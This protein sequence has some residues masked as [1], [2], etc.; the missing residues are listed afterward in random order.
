[1][2]FT[3]GL[4]GWT[5]NDWSRSGNFDLMAPRAEVDGLTRDRVFA[6]LKESW[7]ATPE[8]L[9]AK[10]Q[11]DRATVL[12]AL[13]IWTQ[14][15]RAIYDLDQGV[16][17]CRELSQDPLPLDALRFANP[18]EEA[19]TRFLDDRRVQLT[20]QRLG[21]DGLLHLQGTVRDRRNETVTVVVDGDERI[22]RAT[23]TCSFFIQNK[24][25]KGPC[26]HI[27]AV[28]MQSAA[29]VARHHQVRA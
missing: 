28:R 15:G 26:Q 29:E 6:A 5:A 9:A 19:A 20:E 25:Q 12:G 17:R 10:T 1:M 2:S 3:L 11:L 21:A 16:Y 24:L 23:C 18:R 27:L 13:S 22:R 4:S 8:A 14:A 7:F